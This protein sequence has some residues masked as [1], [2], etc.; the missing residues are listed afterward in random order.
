M[1]D[2]ASLT[3]TRYGHFDRLLASCK[4]LPPLKIAVVAPEEENALNGALL[5]ADENLITPILIG[6]AGKIASAAQALGRDV[7]GFEIID[8]RSHD[9]AAAKAVALIHEGHANALMKGHL[10]TE[11]LLRHVVKRE[12][13]LRT[14]RRL[15]HVYAFDVAGLDRMLLISDAAINIAPDLAAKVDITQNAIDV[16]LAVGLTQPK[17]AVLSAVET[18]NPQIP[19]TIDAATLSKMAERGQIKGGI[20]DG[21]LAMDNAMDLEAAKT[22]GITSPVAGRAEVLIVPNLEAG[23]MVAKELIFVAHADCAGIVVGAKVP[24]ILT[25]RADNAKARLIS[26]AMAVLCEAAK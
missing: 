26:S 8:I 7:S 4:G 1:T 24:I 11:E 5:G 9:Q 23:N 10:H 18:V 25:S 16:A 12:G 2:N 3:L 6:D 15:S 13:G 20:V 17:V 14:K 19:S 21:P 22:K